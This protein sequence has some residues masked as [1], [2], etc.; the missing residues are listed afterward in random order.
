MTLQIIVGMQ[1]GD[2]GKGRF[3]DLLSKDA[4]IAA[5]YNGG[6]NAGHTI[7]IGDEVYKLHLIP[8]GIIYPQTIGVMGNG[9]VINPQILLKEMKELR[10]AGV[11]INPQRLKIS[12]A[13]HMITPA[14]RAMDLVREA[15]LGNA[16]IGTTGRGIGPAYADKAH[17]IGVRYIDILEPDTFREKL[18]RNLE[19]ANDV[20]CKRYNS[21]PVDIAAVFMEYMEYADIL[22]PYIA[23]TSKIVSEALLQ[24]QLVIGEGA[25][26]AMLDIDY[27]TYPYNTSSPCLS[28]GAMT[29][30][31]I[32][33]PKDVEV[34][35]IAKVFQT[36]VGSGAFPT[37]LFNEEALRLRGDGSKQWDEYGTTTGR[38]RRVGWLDLVLLKEICRLNGVNALA[39][40][41]LDV[42]SGMDSI[43]VCTGYGDTASPIS[44]LLVNE[45]TKAEYKT[46]RGWNEDI[47][48]V[49]EWHT[50]PQA[51]R[52]YV[53]FI[54]KC[55]EVPVHWVSVG[56]ERNSLITK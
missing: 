26:G 37:E 48:D 10:A 32:A 13:A 18:T 24:K 6:D 20:L 11:E 2:E 50:L 25:Q 1:W 12:Y 7:R 45:N 54:E 30:L 52:D 4:H 47:G 16:K 42:L 46:F 27:G 34:F 9:M 56:A 53:E 51:A 41:K 17:R 29:G 36:R 44:P 38:P 22:A 55:V 39:L 28:T 23:D 31:G 15:H 5:R 8:S 14:H 43:K 49:R 19:E 35:G 3:V 33:I 40:T 21:D